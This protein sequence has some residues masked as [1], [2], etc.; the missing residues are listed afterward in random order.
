MCVTNV[1]LFLSFNFLEYFTE[2]RV[3]GDT[4][5]SV[6]YLGNKFNSQMVCGVYYQD[7][8][9]VILHYNYHYGIY[10]IPLIII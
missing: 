1:D 8:F 9:L 10:L 6:E 7:H 4:I 5:R 3:K 2:C